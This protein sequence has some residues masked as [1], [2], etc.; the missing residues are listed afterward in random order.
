[1]R[2]APPVAITAAIA[3]ANTAAGTIRPVRRARESDTWRMMGRSSGDPRPPPVTGYTCAGARGVTARGAPPGPH[4]AGTVRPAPGGT[5]GAAGLTL[6]ARRSTMRCGRLFG[7]R[8]AAGRGRA[9]R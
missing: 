6:A 8:R 1:A 5:G 4:P 9:G 3:V 2:A 7:R